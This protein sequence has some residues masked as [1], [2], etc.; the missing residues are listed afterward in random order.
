[1][2]EGGQLPWKRQTIDV[3]RGPVA[4]YSQLRKQL[5]PPPKGLEWHKCNETGEWKL[6]EQAL[7]SPAPDTATAT[8]D[9][10]TGTG[11]DTTE[12]SNPTDPVDH[13]FHTVLPSDTLAGLCLRYKI[14]ATKLRQANKFSGTNLALAP[15]RL[16]IPLSSA[17]TIQALQKLK[18]QDTSSEEYKM[19]AFVAEFPHLKQCE[20]RAYLDLNDGVL[21]DALRN[22][23]DDD[24][25]EQDKQRVK[26]RAEE[27]QRMH[28]LSRLNDPIQQRQYRQPCVPAFVEVYCPEG[29]LEPL[30]KEE[31]ELPNIVS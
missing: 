26:A 24:A 1:M 22:A 30:L 6:Q 25:W 10:V 3:S 18:Q 27:A 13:L 16:L 9:A 15:A 17:L 5:P 21:A 19:Q 11:L 8:T 12:E 23:A 31:L 14:S 29:L 2:A 28:T 20:R 7:L 4:D